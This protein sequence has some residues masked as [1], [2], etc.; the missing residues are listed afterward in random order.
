C[1]STESFGKIHNEIK[2][3]SGCALQ[4]LYRISFPPLKMWSKTLKP[5]IYKGKKANF[6]FALGVCQSKELM[7]F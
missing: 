6:K 7:I 3:F 4:I 2:R 1:I 5:L